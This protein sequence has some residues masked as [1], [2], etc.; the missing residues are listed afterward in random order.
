M[1][2]NLPTLRPTLAPSLTELFRPPSVES[3]A[4][5]KLNHT[6]LRLKLSM[7]LKILRPGKFQLWCR[8]GS[9]NTPDAQLPFALS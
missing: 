8:E 4:G 7:S 9:Q 2:R 1:P 6:L 3:K 5:N